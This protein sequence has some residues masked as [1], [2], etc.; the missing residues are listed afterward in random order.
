MY[1]YAAEANPQSQRTAAQR[2][3]SRWLKQEEKYNK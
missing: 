2:T 3:S 1:A